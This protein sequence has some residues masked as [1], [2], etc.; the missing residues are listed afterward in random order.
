[1]PDMSAFVNSVVIAQ[2]ADAVTGAIGFFLLQ[3]YQVESIALMGYFRRSYFKYS[4]RRY[5]EAD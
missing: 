5:Q 1:M 3:Q 4:I 2:T